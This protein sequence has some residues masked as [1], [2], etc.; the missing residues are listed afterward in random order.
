[1]NEP[2][3]F[4][5]GDTV[6]W[7]EDFSTDYPADDGWALTYYFRGDS[8]LDVTAVANGKTFDV[9]ITATQSNKLVKG[10]YSFIARATKAAE[11]F[12]VSEGRVE[13]FANLAEEIA[14]FE[15]RSKIR[16]A[17]DQVETAIT[18]YSVRPVEAMTV[19]G[20]TLTRPTLSELFKLRSKLLFE[21]EQ[22]KRKERVDKG[23]DPGGLILSRM[24]ET[25]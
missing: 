21:L 24:R 11:I 4:R 18:D 3:K 13:V 12:T 1:M 23:L 14:G 8:K 10:V 20:R 2:T 25:S 7:S 16:I 22:E 15:G 6:E 17:L 9:T 5:R 19:A